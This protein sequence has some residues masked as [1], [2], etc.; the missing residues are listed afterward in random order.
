MHAF[1][2]PIRFVDPDGRWP[3][4]FNFTEDYKKKIDN[5]WASLEFDK[6]RGFSDGYVVNRRGRTRRVD[7][8]GG[9]D[10][11]VIWSEADYDAGN[12]DYGESGSGIKISK[13]ILQSGGKGNLFAPDAEGHGPIVGRYRYYHVQSDT[14]ATAIFEFLY[15]HTDV[16]WGNT[17][18][19][20]SAGK[21]FNILMTSFSD[22]TIGG[23]TYIINR[24]FLRGGFRVIRDDHSHPLKYSP[25]PS[26]Q[27]G[28]DARDI[29][30][31]LDIQSHSPNAIFRIYYNRQY[32]PYSP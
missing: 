4:D 3:I 26:G 12:R 7:D 16:E 32:Y 10:Y 25:R 2:N 28:G 9:D 24:Y 30:R 21:G 22:A 20:N 5:E 14:E 6:Y 17:M 27:R 8:T 11:D 15:K 31:A 23:S 18:L 13:G 1:N 19:R 29:P